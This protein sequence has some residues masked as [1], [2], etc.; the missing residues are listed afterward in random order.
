[1]DRKIDRFI[2]KNSWEGKTSAEHQTVLSRNP[3]LDRVGPGTTRFDEQWLIKHS[4][5]TAIRRKRFDGD[6]EGG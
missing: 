2:M 3:Q 6:H 1:M 4:V 5:Q